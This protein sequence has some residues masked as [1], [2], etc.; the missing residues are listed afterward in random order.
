[1]P[2][3][4]AEIWQE[5]DKFIGMASVKAE[6]RS[7]VDDIKE[8]KRS[9][10]NDVQVEI[11]DHFV[12]TGNPGTGKTTMARCFADILNALGVLPKGHLVEV[13]SKDLI[14]DVFSST[15]HTVSTTVQVT[16]RVQLTPC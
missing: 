11:R 15:K 9:K 13:G 14:G 8:T 16:A 5:L 7:I 1:M 12:F 3:T 10:G 2:R 6:I 4:E